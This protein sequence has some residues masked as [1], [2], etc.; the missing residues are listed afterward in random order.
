MYPISFLVKML[1]K[2]LEHLCALVQHG[3]SFPVR[4]E[5]HLSITEA[6]KRKEKLHEL[7]EVSDA[8]D[9]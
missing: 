9:I 1:Y 5:H 7:L 6:Q 3:D 2:G 8:Q 4:V